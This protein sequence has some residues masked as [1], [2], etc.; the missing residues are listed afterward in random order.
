VIEHLLMPHPVAGPRLGEQIGCVAHRFEPACHD[1]IVRAGPQQVVRQHGRLHARAAHLVDRRAFGGL[2]QPGTEC[3]LPCR[4]LSQSGREHTTH[5][6][7]FD[8]VRP[9]PGALHS[10]ANRGCAELRAGEGLE[11]AL[12]GAHRGA[13]HSG[14]NDG[15]RDCHG[16]FLR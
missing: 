9:N 12:E 16:E 13:G 15:I 14:D 1:D 11:F 10:G 2:R 7:G 6:Y 3:R 4:R 8:L 5:Q